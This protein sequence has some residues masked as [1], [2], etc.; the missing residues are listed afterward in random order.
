[1]NK[2]LK[3]LCS[4]LAVVI[5]YAGTFLVVWIE[6]RSPRPPNSSLSANDKAVLEDIE[7]ILTHY[8]DSTEDH[9]DRSSKKLKN[10]DTTV[11]RISQQAEWEDW[12]GNV[13]KQIL[14][15]AQLVRNGQ[16]RLESV[17][18]MLVAEVKLIKLVTKGLREAVNRRDL[19][20]TTQDI[21]LWAPKIEEMLN[22][23]DIEITKT[24][25]G[26]AIDPTSLPIPAREEW[27]SLALTNLEQQGDL[28]SAKNIHTDVT[29]AANSLKKLVDRTHITYQ[30]LR[31]PF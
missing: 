4:A 30:M 12:Y 14:S 2:G 18:K 23:T 24:K 6:S 3:I 29:M 22:E 8:L 27:N 25:L 7:V 9:A 21:D 13:G 20:K 5:S 11:Q 10:L 15:D 28:S 16:R 31:F 19:I 26:L 1:M 17:Q